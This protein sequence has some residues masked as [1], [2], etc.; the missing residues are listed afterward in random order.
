MIRNFTEKSAREEAST[1]PI[2]LGHVSSQGLL[3]T[4]CGSRHHISHPYQVINCNSKGE[5][6]S[7]PVCPTMPCLS[8]EP[9]RLQPPQ[10]FLDAL[11]FPLTD[12]ISSMPCRAIIDRTRSVLGVLSHVR[13]H[14]EASCLPDKFL[15]VVGF[16]PSNR[17][18]AFPL[19]F[20]KH[21]NRGLSFCRARGFRDT[22]VNR[23]AVPI[24]HQQVS[25]VAQLRFLAFG[26]LVQSCIRIRCR[27]MRCVRSLFPF[28][29]HRRISRIIGRTTRFIASSLEALFSAHA[30]IS[31]PSTVKCSS[32]SR[33]CARA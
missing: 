33:C 14:T 26:L 24:F 19:Q 25:Q 6:P 29:I 31:V 4:S 16:V 20:S 13:S 7:D 3:P 32:D 11:S 22:R 10:D 9:N 12:R 27:F 23:E 15:R 2:S 8:Q 21:V 17:D 1:C 5:H 28:E 18:A 30:S